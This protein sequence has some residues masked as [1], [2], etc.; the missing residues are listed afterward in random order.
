VKIINACSQ[1][2]L[3]VTSNNLYQLVIA[4]GFQPDVIVGIANGGWH[5]VNSM[6]IPSDI[7]RVKILKQRAGTVAKNTFKV[8]VFL[9]LLPR[10][11]NDFLRVAE[12]KYR[13]VVFLASKNKL[14]VDNLEIGSVDIDFIQKSNRVLIV[15]D[16][17]DSGVTLKAVRDYLVSINC[18]ANYKVAV[19]NT[20]FSRSLLLPDYCLYPRTIVRLPWAADVVGGVKYS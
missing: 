2:D 17:I 10:F 5:V 12:V 15:D 20:T 13:E 16:C 14:R 3:E 19:I 11:L 18:Q 9:P 7:R 4:D 6:S 8:G 1:I